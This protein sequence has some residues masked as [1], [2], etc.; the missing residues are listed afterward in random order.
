MSTPAQDTNPRLEAALDLAARGFHIVP[1]QWNEKRTDK[2]L[3]PSGFEDASRDPATIRQWFAL[4]PRINIG[5]ATGRRFG[6]VAL[7]VDVK[8]G[9]PGL[10]TLQRLAVDVMTLT[11]RT[12][13]GGYHL[14]FKAPNVPLRPELPGINVKGADGCGYCL[15]PPSALPDYGEY[16]W[17]DLEIPVAELTPHLLEALKVGKPAKPKPDG[18]VA[19]LLV[20]AGHRHQRLS[21]LCAIYRGKGLDAF[22]IET[23]LWEHATRYFDPPFNRSNPKEVQEVR[24]LIDWIMA[25]PAGTEPVSEAGVLMHT[26]AEL[27][28]LAGAAPVAQLIEPVLPHAGNLLIY[29]ASGVGKSHLGLCIALLLARGGS[30]LGW[31]VA[32]PVNVL[33]VDGE[34]PLQELRTRLDAYLTGAPYPERLHWIAARAQRR[35]GKYFDMPDLNTEA[36]QAQYLAKI[37]Q[38]SAVVTVFDNLATLRTT[39]ADAPENSVEGFSP[40]G[41]L[42]RRINNRGTATI[43]LHHA[44]RA[45][46][47][48]G[49]SAHTAPM[50][51][52]ICLRAVLPP[53]ADPL[54]ANDV[55]I[56]PAD[57]H[58]CFYGEDAAK[59]RAKAFEDCD[60]FVRWQRVGDDPLAEDVARLRL[61]GVSVRDIAKQLKRSKNGIQKAIERAKARALLVPGG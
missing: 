3:A 42:I 54:A 44:N 47:Q 22:E 48:R 12:P 38:C 57:K 11:A 41:A 49:S 25:K 35:E 51:T 14:Y 34:M 59:F 2:L 39:S 24:N 53:Q 4:K 6:V 10:Q 58:R 36:G 37:E 27:A 45:G 28:A 1:V 56:D 40:V 60:G 61:Q 20:H 29:G 32:Q 55:E 50:D 23:L 16:R 8:D 46:T 5:V 18:P 30:F 26:S 15:A 43:W 31:T 52:V 19:E 9:A 7:D 17:L 33:Y 21:D 13:T